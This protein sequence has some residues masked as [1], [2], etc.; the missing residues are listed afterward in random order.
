MKKLTPE[1]RKNQF[2]FPRQNTN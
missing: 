1:L 2:K